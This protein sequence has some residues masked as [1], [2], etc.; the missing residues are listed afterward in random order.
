MKNLVSVIIPIYNADEYIE[1]CLNSVINQ[2]YREIEIIIINDGSTDKSLEI[3]RK[4]KKEDERIIILDKN[5]TGVSDSRN[6]GIDIA[7]GEYITFI[8]SDDYIEKDMID[9]LVRSIRENRSDISICGFYHVNDKKYISKTKNSKKNILDKDEFIEEILR[10]RFFIASL[11]GK[12]FRRELLKQERLD[13]NLKI[14][15]DLEYLL[16]I[17]LKVEHISL[18]NDKLYNYYINSDSATNNA[19]FE[20]Y[21]DELNVLESYLE[22][23]NEFY[24]LFL[25]RYLRINLN[26]YFRYRKSDLKNAN[27]CCRIIKDIPMKIGMSRYFDMKM[28]LKYLIVKFLLN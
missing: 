19:K 1:R 14:A 6:K 16:R 28:K 11:W 5:N 27:R 9:I 18:V 8:D 4:F 26:L 15:E 7:K 20:K 21:N 2:T 24:N 23:K 12:L 3:I 25:S 17:S 22:T 13:C 10:E